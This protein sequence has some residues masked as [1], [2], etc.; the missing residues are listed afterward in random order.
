MAYSI[1][2]IQCS[3]WK[4]ITSVELISTQLRRLIGCSATLVAGDVKEC[5]GLRPGPHTV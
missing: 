2:C 1:C 5:L 4:T 3:E